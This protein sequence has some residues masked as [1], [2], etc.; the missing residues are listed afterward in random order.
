MFEEEPPQPNQRR[1]PLCLI[2]ALMAM[3]LLPLESIARANKPESTL[4]LIFQ[5]LRNKTETE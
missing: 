5:K 2:I 3:I 1:R 4:D